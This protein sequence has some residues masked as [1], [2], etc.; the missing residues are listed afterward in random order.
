MNSTWNIHSSLKLAFDTGFAA[1]GPL[2]EKV[3][4]FKLTGAESGFQLAIGLSSDIDL[5]PLQHEVASRYILKM[6]GYQI[7]G[8]GIY[9]KPGR[10]TLTVSGT[11]F[12]PPEDD[13]GIQRALL[14]AINDVARESILWVE[15]YKWSN[16]PFEDGAPRRI[17]GEKA[18]SFIKALVGR[19]LQLIIKELEYFEGKTNQGIDLKIEGPF[20]TGGEVRTGYLPMEKFLLPGRYTVC[21]NACAYSFPCYNDCLTNYA[22]EPIWTSPELV[23]E[24]SPGGIIYLRVGVALDQRVL[25][26]AENTFFNQKNR[27]QLSPPP[28]PRVNVYLELCQQ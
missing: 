20:T 25:N 28:P 16:T 1:S 9:F 4:A 6:E 2:W 15:T 27:A 23:I 5:T 11:V 22:Y 17:E 18:Q 12:K 7:S 26:E 13:G 8:R 21:A 3:A 14:V 24:G 10:L 19:S